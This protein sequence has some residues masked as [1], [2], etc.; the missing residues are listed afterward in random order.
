MIYTIVQYRGHVNSYLICFS[1]GTYVLGLFKVVEFAIIIW[2]KK[3]IWRDVSAKI[4]R[5]QV[6]LASRCIICL[7]DCGNGISICRDSW[8][9]F[10]PTIL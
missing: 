6:G 3:I 9:A 1:Y 4:E 8:G 7:D 2:V 10:R 5:A